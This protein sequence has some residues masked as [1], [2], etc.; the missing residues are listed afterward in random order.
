M[1]FFLKCVYK[2]ADVFVTDPFTD[3]IEFGI[4]LHQQFHRF[5]KPDICQISFIIDN[6]F[7]FKHIAEIVGADT[8][9]F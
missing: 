8:G 1:I 2:S 5:L 7:V 6:S 4:R 3:L 9:D